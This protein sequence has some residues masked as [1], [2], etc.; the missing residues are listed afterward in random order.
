[1]AII[2]SRTQEK[3]QIHIN[4]DKCTSCG[5]CANICKDYS[6]T[7]KEGKMIVN[8]NSFFDCFGCGQCMAICPTGAI[9]VTGREIS[10]D[11]LIPIPP[12]EEKTNYDQL[13]KLMIGRRSIRD[14]KSKDVEE[15]LISKIVEATQTAPMGIPPSDVY[16]TIFKGT[17]K[18]SEFSEDVIEHI[19]K[20]KGMLSKRWLWIWRFSGKETYKMMKS[21]VNPLVE[22]LTDDKQKGIN[23]LLYNAP[24]AIY[25]SA[26]PYSDIADPYIPATY[27]MLAAESLGLGSCMIGC[28]D[29]FLKRG[30]KELKTKWKIPQKSPAGIIVI[31]G[32]PKYKY[33]KALKR[34]FANISTFNNWETKR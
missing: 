16:L 24:L 9:T 11:D 6:L 30:A 5:L 19:T 18:V 31:F 2:T 14:F 7:I 20:I 33:A 15:E 27:A 17:K 25:F 3:G 13:Y 34:T 32:Y 26:S 12:K 21:F 28:V 23:H 8:E 22:G 10:S 4:Y 29:P 1:M